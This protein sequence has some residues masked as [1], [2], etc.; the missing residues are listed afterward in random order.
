M[1]LNNYRT[2]F[3]Q[4]PRRVVRL[5]DQIEKY[6]AEFNAALGSKEIAVEREPRSISVNKQSY[7]SQHFLLDL[8]DFGIA[9]FEPKVLVGS[10]ATNL[11][12]A[13][14]FTVS[15]ATS[16]AWRSSMSRPVKDRRFRVRTAEFW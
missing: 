9:I 10:E 13:M 6:V 12:R 16:K 8:A 15:N 2:N 11:E 14:K 4:L 5:C 1:R 3:R 7:P